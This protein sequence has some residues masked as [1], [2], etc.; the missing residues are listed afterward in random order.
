[1][2]DKA[3][4]QIAEYSRILAHLLSDVFEQNYLI[5]QTK[6]LLSKTQFRVL[7]IL[8][9]SGQYTVSE[10]ATI[11][12]IS[13]A[14]ASKNIDKLVRLKLVNRKITRSDRRVME[15]SL[16]RA[17]QAI[18]DKYEKLRMRKQHHALA[19]FSREEKNK[20]LELLKI[21][22][23]HSLSCEKN[24]DVICLQCNGGIAQECS[25]SKNK[26]RCRFYNRINNNQI[27]FEKED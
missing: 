18:V 25:F 3:T 11:L 27:T 24:I 15:V 6:G 4:R 19:H 2:A 8:S 12:H 1:V 9:V 21:Y 16:T 10:I 17:G 26:N 20:L 13:C 23:H 22:V 5:E 7:K 14:A